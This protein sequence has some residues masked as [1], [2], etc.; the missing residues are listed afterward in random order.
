VVDPLLVLPVVPDVPEAVVLPVDEVPTEPPLDVVPPV[1]VPPDVPP[2]EVDDPVVPCDVPLVV[3]AGD[4]VPAP[5]PAINRANNN[6]NTSF[7]FDVIVRNPPSLELRSM[8]SKDELLT[9]QAELV[10]T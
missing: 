5:H 2:V 4:A 9:R 3:D 6:S 10:G 7:C 8:G 1:V